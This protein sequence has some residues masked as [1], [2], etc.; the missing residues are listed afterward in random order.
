MALNNKMRDVTYDV[1]SLYIVTKA[2][3][4]PH[5]ISD[6]SVVLR[7]ISTFLR[8]KLSTQGN[9]S[10][11]RHLRFVWRSV[12]L[13]VVFVF[14]VVSTIWPLLLSLDTTG[15]VS[16]VV[17][18]WKW[19]IVKWSNSE[20]PSGLILLAACRR[21]CPLKRKEFRG[22]PICPSRSGKTKPPNHFD[23]RVNLHDPQTCSDAKA[24]CLDEGNGSVSLFGRLAVCTL[25]LCLVLMA[26]T[27]PSAL[28]YNLPQS[29][30]KKTPEH[31]ELSCS[32]CHQ[33]A[34]I[35]S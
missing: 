34:Y 23:G 11:S 12:C 6:I 17:S 20:V 3:S 4:Q 35:C 13:S 24:R 8:S 2:T 15:N 5:G 19:N 18:V 30:I 26:L 9:N 27:L 22:M 7:Q 28:Y 33:N 10:I 16:D 31:P 14:H 1:I 21:V 25:S 29:Q 32:C